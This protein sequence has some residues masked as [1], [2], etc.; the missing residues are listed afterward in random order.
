MA[1]ARIREALQDPRNGLQLTYGDRWLVGDGKGGWVV[2][3]NG[4]YQ[5]G[6]TTVIQ[7]D[8]EAEA[9]NVLLYREEATGNA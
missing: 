9:V 2:Y 5:S 7:T 1:E 6:T 3:S 4:L 8:D